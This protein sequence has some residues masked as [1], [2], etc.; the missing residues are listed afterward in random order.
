MEQFSTLVFFH[1]NAYSA[2]YLQKTVFLG[3]VKP[4]LKKKER[5]DIVGF[6]VCFFGHQS[7]P[8]STIRPLPVQFA[9]F[10]PYLP[11]LISMIF[12]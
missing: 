6:L 11:T 12:C 7:T 4:P 3:G 9:L 2:R 10:F 8:F 5:V 1:K